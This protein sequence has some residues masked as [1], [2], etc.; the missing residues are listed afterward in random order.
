M[1]KKII[2]ITIFCS[3][4]IMGAVSSSVASY[5]KP[6]LPGDDNGT[7]YYQTMRYCSGRLTYACTTV[8]LA[9]SCRR[10]ACLTSY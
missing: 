1:K 4:V 9:E 6:S 10:Y 3:F 7:T 5:D 8:S 2:G